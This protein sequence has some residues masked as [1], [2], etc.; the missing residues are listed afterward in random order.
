[1]HMK[2][3]WTA[4]EPVLATQPMESPTLSEAAAVALARDEDLENL[5]FVDG[6]LTGFSGKT[7][8]VRGCVFERCRF[9]DND[10]KRISFVDCVFDKCEWSNARLTNAAFQRARLRGCRM[11]GLEIMRGA[12][13]NVA[14][15][16]C[17]LD[18]ASFAECKLDH[19]VFSD[20]RLRDSLWSENRLSRVRFDHSDLE[21]AQW[22]RTQLSGLDMTTCRIAGWTVSLTD[23]R[24]MKVTGGAGARPGR[25]AGRGDRFIKKQ[26]DAAGHLR[27][28]PR[29]ACPGERLSRPPDTP[30][31]PR[32]FRV[33]SSTGALMVTTAVPFSWLTSAE[34]TPG[35][36]L[37]R[38]FDA[39]GTVGAHHTFDLQGFLHGFWLLRK[40]DFMVLP[41]AVRVKQ[42]QAQRVGDDAEAG[43]AHGRGPEHGVELPS[44][45]GNKHPCCPAGS[46]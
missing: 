32:P 42:I 7:L 31:P 25:A 5:R 3:G 12:L 29:L 17:M 16:G 43:Q 26:Q 44:Q 45:Q 15:D 28:P 9:G 1:M 34:T 19:A 37:Q 8:D 18:Y 36:L 38:L 6:E 46:R 30:G 39:A 40:F 4:A 23:L 10:F 22:A 20:C 14:F 41:R 2:D 13:M 24:G 33:A 21:R 35:Q 11:T 27:I